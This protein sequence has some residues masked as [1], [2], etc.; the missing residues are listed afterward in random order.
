MALRGTATGSCR[1][2]GPAPAPEATPVRTAARSAGIHPATPL[3]HRS[4]ALE[5]GTKPLCLS[6]ADDC[7]CE[8]GEGEVQVGA[9]FVADGETA[10]AGKPRQGALH[11]PAVASQALA[12][13]DAAPGYPRRD[14]A[15]P[16]LAPTAAMIVALVS[17][18]LVWSA[19]RATAPTCAHARHR[20]QRGGQHA[21]VVA[22]GP[23][24]PQAERCAVGVHD[25]VAL[26]PRLAPVRRVRARRETP[27]F[28]G[29]LA[30]SRA[31]RDQSSA[32]AS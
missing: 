1:E 6:L 29:R 5:S 27:F 32:F 12:A 14:A 4:T 28:A 15:S 9:T 8:G 16:A 30:L 18:Q 25:K 31:A 24:E 26:R 21:A 23:G 11:D 13:L 17:V 10:E 2:R 3:P 20:I 22:V 7:A 19:S